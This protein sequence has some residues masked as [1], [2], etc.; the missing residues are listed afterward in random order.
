MIGKPEDESIVNPERWVS[1]VDEALRSRG[2]GTREC[3]DRW[4]L[5]FRYTNALEQLKEDYEF[6]GLGL[7]GED[8]IY[9]IKR[10]DVDIAFRYIGIGA[11]YAGMM[12]EEIIARGARYII[13][14]GG[15]GVLTDEIPRWSF[16]LPTAAIRDEGVSYHYNPPSFLAY[17]S[18]LLVAELE[19]SFVEEGEGYFK[20]ITWTTDAPYRETRFKRELFMKK[21]TICVEMEAAALFS[22]AKY[23]GVDIAAV[24]YAGDLV[25]DEW[26]LRVSED[27]GRKLAET[28]RK[29][30][31][32][33]IE[34]LREI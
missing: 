15:A 31:R 12:L 6:E 24:L 18:S 21:G 1:F 11:S 16:I 27:D 33:S 17:P 2:I 19:E 23:R 25:G 22:I 28:C 29:M 32:L 20:G 3:P 26:D 30:L 34:V 14:F 7:G 8:D 5:T 13:F 10:G 4:I 9:F